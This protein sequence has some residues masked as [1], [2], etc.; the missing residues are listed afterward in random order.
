VG[1]GIRISQQP[2]QIR[3]IHRVHGQHLTPEERARRRDDR[4]TAHAF[5]H[6]RDQ[7]HTDDE[8]PPT[9]KQLQLLW[10]LGYRG[11]RPR[12]R[13]EVMALV[14]ELGQREVGYPIRLGL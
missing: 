12:T 3:I 7:F 8:R 2:C 1:S 4:H 11:P 9:Y 6:R 10:C 5:D 13:A 14:A